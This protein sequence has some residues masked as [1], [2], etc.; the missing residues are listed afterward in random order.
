MGKLYL[1]LR[2]TNGHYTQVTLVEWSVHKQLLHRQTLKDLKKPRLEAE[3]QEC[4]I[5]TRT[6]FERMRSV[7]EDYIYIYVSEPQLCEFYNR[8]IIQIY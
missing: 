2:K 7:L 1:Y 5:K 4:I 8:L 6:L 3:P